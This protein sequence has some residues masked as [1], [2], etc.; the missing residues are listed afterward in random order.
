M[1][2][3]SAIVAREPDPWYAMLINGHIDNR[4]GFVGMTRLRLA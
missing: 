3:T 1:A 2:F 4:G